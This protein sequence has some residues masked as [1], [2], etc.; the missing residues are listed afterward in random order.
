MILIH[1]IL[2]DGRAL[3]AWVLRTCWRRLLS[4]SATIHAI[5]ASGVFIVKQNKARLYTDA[6]QA[7][8][9]K[10]QLNAKSTRVDILTRDEVIVLGTSTVAS[11]YHA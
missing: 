6:R 1:R 2:H 10:K 5:D 3:P 7:H 9:L 4:L 11:G 8:A